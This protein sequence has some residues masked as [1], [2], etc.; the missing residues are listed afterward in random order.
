MLKVSSV[1]WVSSL[2]LQML[3]SKS[4][5]ASDIEAIEDDS[6]LRPPKFAYQRKTINCFY[7]DGVISENITEC[8][9][10]NLHEELPDAC[11]G[12]CYLR[13]FI[14]ENKASNTIIKRGCS[15]YSINAC[16]EAEDIAGEKYKM[17]VKSCKTDLCNI[18][19][20]SS[21]NL[22]VNNFLMW[23]FLVLS[24]FVMSK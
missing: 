6:Y 7:C 12:F 16:M 8:N 19:D 22:N 10:E 15:K 18:G 1:I 5:I 21:K 14:P 2:L 4:A 24:V 9:H 13:V 23:S 20:S 11:T 17:C 3:V